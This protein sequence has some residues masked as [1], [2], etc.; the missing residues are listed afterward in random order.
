LSTIGLSRF[1]IS[2][3]MQMR[4][5]PSPPWPMP[6]CLQSRFHLRALRRRHVRHHLLH[7]VGGAGHLRGLVATVDDRLTIL[8]SH[9]PGLR[10]IPG[11]RR[12]SAASV[13]ERDQRNCGWFRTC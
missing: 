9:R 6:C 11:V 13:G 10:P 2:G 8:T 5:P 12:S 4:K 1:A 7:A 3:V